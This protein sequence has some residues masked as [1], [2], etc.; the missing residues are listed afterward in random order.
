MADMTA[1]AMMLRQIGEQA[2]VLA[3]GD[4]YRF[5]FFAALLAVA[6]SFLLPGRGAVKADPSMMAGGH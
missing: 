3:F 5:T 2:A 6:L 1:L 4:A